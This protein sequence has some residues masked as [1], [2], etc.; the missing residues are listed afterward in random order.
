M[1]SPAKREPKLP[2]LS[3]AQVRLYGLGW[4]VLLLGWAAAAWVY[5]VAVEPAPTDVLG[6]DLAGGGAYATRAGDSKRYQ[7][8]MERFGGKAS[9]L[10]VELRDAAASLWQGRRRAY[11][12]AVLT[13]LAALGCFAL[14][15]ILPD[16]PSFD[17]DLSP[18]RR[19]APPPGP[20]PLP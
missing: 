15:E 17:Y 3:R 8:D 2:R 11:T 20:P 13:G 5:G 10:A 9:I 19:A 6:Y 7:Y 14:A 18:P 12:L 16:L 4:T 1:P